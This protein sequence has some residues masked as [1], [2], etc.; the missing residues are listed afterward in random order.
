MGPK[1]TVDSA[2]LMNKGFE[3]MEAHWLFGYPLSQIEVM[4]HRESI[5][6]SMVVFPDGAIKAQLG[7][8]DMRVPLQFALT[9]PQRL[10]SPAA[11]VDLTSL[12]PL[13]FG[14]VDASRYPCLR[15]ARE[16]ADLGGTYPAVLSAA[17]EAAV[18]LFLDGRIGFTEIHRQV[19]EALQR[20][21]NIADPGLDDVLEADAWARRQVSLSVAV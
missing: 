9:Y 14:T 6:H 18:G 15:L 1:I 20:H 2:T 3:V 4:L 5:V 16:A 8:P 11:S 21:Q 13:S 12:G 17:D 10:P 19:E 7:A